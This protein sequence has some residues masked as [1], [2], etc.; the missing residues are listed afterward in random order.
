[1]LPDEK[2]DVMT[3]YVLWLRYIPVLQAHEAES[4][5]ADFALVR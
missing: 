4:A 3:L 2:F 5:K 1:V